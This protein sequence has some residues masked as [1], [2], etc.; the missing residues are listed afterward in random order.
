MT[1]SDSRTRAYVTPSLPACSAPEFV[2]CCQCVTLPEPSCPAPQS[3][4][5][6]GD[7]QGLASKD[8]MR[9]NTGFCPRAAGSAHGTGCGL[10]TSGLL[11]QGPESLSGRSSRINI[12]SLPSVSELRFRFSC[13]LR[14]SS[15]SQAQSQG[16]LGLHSVPQVSEFLNVRPVNEDWG[17]VTAKRALKTRTAGQAGGFPR[18]VA[19]TKGNKVRRSP[20]HHPAPPSPRLPG[21]GSWRA[22][23]HTSKELGEMEPRPPPRARL[24]GRGLMASPTP[25]PNQPTSSRR[26][27]RRRASTAEEGATP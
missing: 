25:G 23:L 4:V 10:A 11:N 19:E 18:H 6:R 7:M 1:E 20:A 2:R 17:S 12:D 13:K 5:L 26:R 27:L 8:D 24:P 22:L 3:R 14:S 15:V 9:G 16:T 21:R